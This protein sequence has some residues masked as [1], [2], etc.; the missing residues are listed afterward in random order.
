M[1]PARLT[2]NRRTVLDLFSIACMKLSA[3]PPVPSSEVY[4]DD[5]ASSCRSLWGT[6]LWSLSADESRRMDSRTI[7]IGVPD[8]MGL[9]LPRI[10]RVPVGDA[11]IVM[12]TSRTHSQLIVL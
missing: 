8:L 5:S 3:C 9:F 6:T 2:P 10:V 7:S 1:N 11:S 4:P 12:F